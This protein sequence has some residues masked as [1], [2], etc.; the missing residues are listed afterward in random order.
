MEA[1]CR[2]VLA[3]RQATQTREDSTLYV[4]VMASRHKMLTVQQ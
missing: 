4:A 3:S 2:L 1:L